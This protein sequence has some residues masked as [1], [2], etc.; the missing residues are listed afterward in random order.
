M[1]AIIPLD[2]P[3]LATFISN[4]PEG[5]TSK[6]NSSFLFGLAPGRV[7]R[8]FL[9]TQKAV[10]FYLAFSPLLSFLPRG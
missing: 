3:L 4:Q 8:A 1:E 7:C 9:I 2:A 5:L 6:V 10:S